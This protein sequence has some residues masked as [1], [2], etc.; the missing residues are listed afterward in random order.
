[1]FLN[2]AAILASVEHG[3]I[4]ENRNFLLY[5]SFRYWI[6]FLYVTFQAVFI[7]CSHGAK[8]SHLP[9]SK[10]FNCKDSLLLLFLILFLIIFIYFFIKIHYYS[11][12][13]RKS[14]FCFIWKN[15]QNTTLLVMSG[16]F[17]SL[18]AGNKFYKIH[19]KKKERKK[20]DLKC[21]FFFYAVSTK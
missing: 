13:T 21:T 4:T 12:V 19:Q 15:S 17:Y 10:S 2:D 16:V 18:T 3:S 5:F 6:F 7:L 9:L 1:M 14:Y 8:Y 11:K 20:T